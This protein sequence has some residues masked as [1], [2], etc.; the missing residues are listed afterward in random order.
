MPRL[1]KVTR[2]L[3]QARKTLSLESREVSK[4]GDA[5]QDGAGVAIADATWGECS[6]VTENET[7]K[8]D[9]GFVAGSKLSGQPRDRTWFGTGCLPIMC[10]CASTVGVYVRT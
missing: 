3:A 2:L 4:M 7:E 1:K 5:G 8:W 6:Q 9:L 10:T